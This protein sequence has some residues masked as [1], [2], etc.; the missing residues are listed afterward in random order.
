MFSPDNSFL[1]NNVYDFGHQLDWMNDTLR[2]VAERGEQAIIIGHASPQDW[3][4][5]FADKFNELMV[6]YRT[7]VVNMFFGH[8]HN[9]EVQLV[10]ATVDSMQ[11]PIIAAYIGGSVTSYTN[12]NPGFTVFAYDRAAVSGNQKQPLPFLATDMSYYWMN[13]TASNE[14]NQALFK[15]GVNAL[16]NYGMKDLS[17]SSWYSLAEAFKAGESKAAFIA[18]QIAF[19]KGFSNGQGG[20]M[21]QQACEIET[22]NPRD[23]STCTSALNEVPRIRKHA[24]SGEAFKKPPLI[25]QAAM[26][27][28]R[29]N[30][31]TADE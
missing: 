11:V 7:S 15:Q 25:R 17:P 24:C 20:N 27:D 29:I 18:M 9:N 22:N 4:Q 10:E 26:R 19:S 1:T 8:T 5:I 6:V 21:K 31:A 23:L 12:V 30:I 13:L 16:H 14:A 2:Q 28:L 3:Y